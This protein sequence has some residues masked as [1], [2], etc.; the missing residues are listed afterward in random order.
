MACP[1]CGNREVYEARNDDPSTGYREIGI[2]CG[3]GHP[4]YDD[5]P[6]VYEVEERKAA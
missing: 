4:L 1:E 5:E 2:V 3:N 6:E